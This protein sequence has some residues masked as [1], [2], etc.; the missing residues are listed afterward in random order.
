MDAVFVLGK[1]VVSIIID[2]RPLATPTVSEKS[3]AVLYA[4]FPA[5][6]GA[7]AIVNIL[8]DK[9]D[10]GG[11]LPVTIL[12]DAGQI[13]MYHSRLPFYADLETTVEYIDNND[14]PR[15]KGLSIRPGFE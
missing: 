3:K 15:P 6:E 13:P 8:T 14:A 7:A 10:P 4:R 1:P 9:C 2:G 5:Q 11:K 12:K